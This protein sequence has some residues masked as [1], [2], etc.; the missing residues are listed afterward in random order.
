MK[1]PT[2][3]KRQQIEEN[4]AEELQVSFEN[5]TDDGADLGTEL[6]EG[7]I[8]EI[9]GE[10]VSENQPA[11]QSKSSGAA[12][13][14]NVKVDELTERAQL[15]ER[16]LQSAPKEP[17]MRRQIKAVLL[18]KRDML[19]GHIRKYKGDKD[20]YLLSLAISQLR[21]VIRQ[22]EIVAKA[23]FEIL[24]EVWLKVVHNFA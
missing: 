5:G 17:E 20:Y 18:K 19:E 10:N 24:R 9:A 8:S 2:P 1:D 13:D 3:Q 15:R 4:S 12:Q 7:R 23:S 11:S 21:A 6:V 16:L 14:D 22:L